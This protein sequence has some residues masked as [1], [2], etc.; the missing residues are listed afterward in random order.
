MNALLLPRCYPRNSRIKKPF[1]PLCT[2]GRGRAVMRTLE[3]GIR[4]LKNA[5]VL[6]SIFAPFG[7]KMLSISCP[8]FLRHTRFARTLAKTVTDYSTLSSALM[9]VRTTCRVS[10]RR[11]LQNL[12]KDTSCFARVTT[13]Q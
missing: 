4:I 3:W 6:L 10:G 1:K 11:T 12:K 5:S 13:A 2:K 7:P 8:S 9:F